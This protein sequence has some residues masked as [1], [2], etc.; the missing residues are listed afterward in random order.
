MCAQP[1]SRRSARCRTRG[2]LSCMLGAGRCGCVCPACRPPSQERSWEWVGIVV[3]PRCLR[4]SLRKAE[5][6]QCRVGNAPESHGT[7]HRAHALDL[8]GGLH[9][10]VLGEP[11]GCSVPTRKRSVLRGSGTARSTGVGLLL[12]RLLHPDTFASGLRQVWHAGF[13]RPHWG[14]TATVES[15]LALGPGGEAAT[16]RGSRHPPFRGVAVVVPGWRGSW[17]R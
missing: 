6:S 17:R 10:H 8:Q 9:V 11:G 14:H 13:E 5:G 2:W 4:T 16:P 3:G 15:L 7:H 12:P 1:C